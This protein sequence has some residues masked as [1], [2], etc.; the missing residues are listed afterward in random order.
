MAHGCTLIAFQYQTGDGKTPDM[1]RG[2]FEIDV[3]HI[4]N[5][6]HRKLRR[7]AEELEN[8]NPAMI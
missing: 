2:S 4:G 5:L 8:L 3:E 7:F 6:A 1:I